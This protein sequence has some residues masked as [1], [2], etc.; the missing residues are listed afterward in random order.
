MVGLGRETWTLESGDDAK[1]GVAP[2]VTEGA[3]GGGAGRGGVGLPAE[4]DIVDVSGEEVL[5]GA[6]GTVGPPL[7][8]APLERGG[9]AGGGPSL[10]GVGRSMTGGGSLTGAGG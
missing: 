1:T 2:A 10:T 9:T 4:G 8:T 6:A 3:R 5:L 7:L